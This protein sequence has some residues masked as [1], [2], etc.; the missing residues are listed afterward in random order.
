MYQDAEMDNL[1]TNLGII[2]NYIGH[3]CGLFK[4]EVGI[5]LENRIDSMYVI[6]Y[7]F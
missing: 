3:F 6:L 2:L 1:K 4:A 5:L 7:Y